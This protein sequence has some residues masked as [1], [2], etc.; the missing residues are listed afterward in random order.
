MDDRLEDAALAPKSTLTL[1][2]QLLF[3]SGT[4]LVFIL[5]LWLLSDVLL[6]FVAGIGLAYLLDPLVQQLQRLGLPRVVAALLIMAAAIVIIA[7]GVTLLVPVLVEQ[8][9]AFVQGLPQDIAKVQKLF[10]EF[11]QTWLGQAVQERLPQAQQSLGGIASAIGGWL[12]GFAASLWSGGKSVVSVISI[13]VIAPIV[14]FYLLLDWDRMVAAIDSWV[15]RQHQ[16]TVRAIARDINDAISGFLRGQAMCCLILGTFYAVALKMIGLNFAILIGLGAG[17]LG[18][19]PYVGTTTG[20]LVSTAV[21]IAQFYPNWAP[22]LMSSG[23][24]VAGQVV[25][26]NV[27]QPYLVGSRTGLHPVW[28]MFA[29]FAFGYLLGFVGLLIAVPVAA[30]IG[31]IMRFLLRQYLA[32]PYYTGA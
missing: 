28:L 18:F 11:K 14:A 27:L 4:L 17:M 10:D 19:I 21:A 30:A 31:V 7:L 23:V 15:P 16:Q 24:F 13:F 25:E 12:T 22:I 5:L 6:P 32:S 3:W 9:S 29:L 26:G 8:V 1:K 20:F 2:R